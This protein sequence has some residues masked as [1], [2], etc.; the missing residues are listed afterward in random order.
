MINITA[1]LEASLL[2]ATSQATTLLTVIKAVLRAG[3]WS[4]HSAAVQEILSAWL[5]MS[6]GRHLLS[7]SGRAEAV[8]TLER[9]HDELMVVYM[10]GDDAPRAVI[11]LIG[12][13]IGVLEAFEISCNLIAE[14]PRIGQAV[15]GMVTTA[16]VS[17]FT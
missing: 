16:L 13:E 3:K 2:M 14:D 6:P 10:A 15:H 11:D 9:I 17:A 5:L 12:A 7:E 4:N 1:E 8:T